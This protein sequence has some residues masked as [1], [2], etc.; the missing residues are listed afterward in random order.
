MQSTLLRVKLDILGSEVP[1]FQ[2][3]GVLGFWGS[4]VPGFP[5][6]KTWAAG[7]RSSG[8]VLREITAIMFW[9]KII[10]NNQG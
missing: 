5:V 7:F 8:V 10:E 1:G 6:P 2:G 4:G 9:L 3:S